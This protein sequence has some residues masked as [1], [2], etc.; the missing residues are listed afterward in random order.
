MR[1]T[2]GSSGRSTPGSDGKCKFCGASQKTLDRGE[3]LETHA[4]A[5]IHT[6]DI[7]TRVAELFG[8]DMQFDVIIGNPPYQM[9]GGAG[10]TSDSSIYHLFV[11]QALR[12]DPRFLTW[13]SRSGGWPVGEA[14]TSFVRRC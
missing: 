2:S 11:E 8:D 10:G 14:W 12:L 7:K 6:D 4:Y 9:K 3:G 5:F 1:A 13:L